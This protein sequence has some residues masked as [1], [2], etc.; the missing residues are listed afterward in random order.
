MGVDVGGTF[1]DIFLLDE[2]G[3]RTLTMKLSSTPD[4]PSRAIVS[5]ATDLLGLHEIRP[6]QLAYLAHGTTVATNTILQRAGARVGMLTTAGFRDLLEIGRQ[7][8]PRVY[9]LF[10]DKP[11]VLVPR[12]LRKEVKERVAFDGTVLADMKLPAVKKL[13]QQLCSARIDALA[14]C[15][16]NAYANPVHEQQAKELVRELNPKVYLSVSHELTSEFREYERFLTTVL[17][18]YV[19]T[20][21]DDYLT[22]LQR[23][24]RRS[25]IRATPHIIQS[26]G[27]LMSIR[28]A[29]NAPIRTVLSGPSAGVV[30]AVHVGRQAGLR[31]IITLDM[32]GTSTDVSLVKD[33]RPSMVSAQQLAGY[34]LRLPTIAIHTI[35]AGG[36]SIAWIDDA[37]GFHVGPSSAGAMPGPAVYGLGGERLTVTDANVLLGR[38]NQEALLD[39]AMPI[40]RTLADKAVAPLA[41]TLKLSEERT[42][43]GV[44]QVIVSAMVRAVRVISVEKGE[45]PRD[46]ALMAFGGAGPLHATAVAKQLGMRTVCVPQAPGLLCSMGAL[47]AVPTMEYSRTKVIG[48]GE[49]L[50]VFLDTDRVSRSELLQA[51][52]RFH[53]EHA[54][55]FGYSSPEDDVQVVTCRVVATGVAAELES[56]L[57][58]A[59][60]GKP[61]AR[62]TR[63]VY[64]EIT[65]KW[66]DCPVFRREELGSGAT[67]EG[68]A[69][70]EQLDA[71]TLLYPDDA[72]IVDEYGNI[73]ITVAV[74]QAEADD[75]A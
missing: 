15:F 65:G 72:A 52:T 67:L 34:S 62:E 64:F 39:G 48:A 33:A 74:E 71:T 4:D 50:T 24:L 44:L 47:L 26:N 5:G 19:G 59:R 45:D 43:A 6:Q 17:N 46:F 18:A 61:V 2:A 13:V 75:N 27:G 10:A 16:L 31:N 32:G 12:H 68:P 7:K 30:G 51:V 23:S 36:G 3:G 42:A 11:L 14:I 35:G 29:A 53:Q 9:D 57:L 69:I 40:Y 56:P 63:P 60:P 1:T 22:N 28:A 37:M 54:K 41:K 8:R 55:Q 38:L 25:G 70:V 21:L 73:L 66:L 49:E 58:A 20:T